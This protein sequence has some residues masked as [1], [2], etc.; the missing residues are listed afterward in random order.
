MATSVQKPRQRRQLRVRSFRACVTCH[1]RKVRC[2]ALSKGIPCT[3]CA[4]F[5]IRCQVPGIE[6]PLVST[7]TS[8][9]KGG[10]KI[11]QRDSS[12]TLTST[13]ASSTQAYQTSPRQDG[14]ASLTK[15]NVLPITSAGHVLYIGESAGFDLL[16][17][18]TQSPV[19]FPMPQ[20]THVLSIPAGL[21]PLEIQILK[22]R[23]AFVLPPKALCDDLI[24]T[25]FSWVHPIVPVINRTKFMSQYRD[26]R[27]PPSMLLL[28]CILLAGA[29]ISTNSQLKVDGS[30]STA[31]ATFYRRAKALYDADYERD[32]IILVQSMLLMGWYWVGPDDI[33]KNMF[34]WS[35]SAITV[36]Q[37]FGLHRS[38]EDSRLS[39]SD[40]RLRRRI[41]WTL[42]TRDRALAVGLGQSVSIN[43]DD[44][45]VDLIVDDDFIEHD[46]NDIDEYPPDPI[47]VDFFVQYVKLCK[48]IGL[49]AS[50]YSKL[51][52][53]GQDCNDINSISA[54]F[55]K[56][57]Q[58]C[59]ITMRWERSK[60]HFWSGILYLHY[61]SA[62]C[63]LHRASS[64]RNRKTLQDTKQSYG[65][66]DGA[67]RAA[68]MITSIIEALSDRQQ[69]RRCPPFIVHSLFSAILI[70]LHVSNTP[71]P[72]IS[73]LAHRRLS[74]CLEAIKDLAQ[75]WVVGRTVLTM[76]EKISGL[77]TEEKPSRSNHGSRSPLKGEV[78]VDLGCADTSDPACSPNNGRLPTEVKD[79]TQRPQDFPN[80]DETLPYCDEYTPVV[81]G[82]SEANP[83]IHDYPP[84]SNLGGPHPQI[85]YSNLLPDATVL[86][87]SMPDTFYVE[88]T[89]RV[90]NPMA[91]IT[92]FTWDQFQIGWQQDYSISVPWSLELDLQ[93][94][95]APTIDTIYPESGSFI[96]TGN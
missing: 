80:C 12:S 30:T 2:D 27:N 11:A 66:P 42:F 23:G 77:S 56:W 71:S 76:I 20:D 90:C 8:R 5:N 28:Q 19:H 21:D 94:L 1:S 18:G 79:S 39:I 7:L 64:P 47:H 37:N 51:S 92:A 35:Q 96:E 44:C 75:V 52:R 84:H 73:R 14:V 86:S 85:G 93:S 82:F 81:I 13:P 70:H 57:N 48:L 38:M 24:K 55:S 33:S 91:D 49:V 46:G 65:S 54:A 74:T 61:F 69:L 88:D 40:K 62:R 41:W 17:R 22:R 36:A 4:A 83:T 95:T 34:Y 26:A 87:G 53:H 6:E 68:N 89:A 15:F 72:S 9:G 32:R 3:N 29:R 16:L 45:D 59:P 58:E 78:F 67:V 60:H 25:Y 43:L 31:V 50:K 10:Q 63:L